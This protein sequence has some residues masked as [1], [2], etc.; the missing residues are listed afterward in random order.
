MAG[1]LSFIHKL[2]QSLPYTVLIQAV[3]RNFAN[4]QIKKKDKNCVVS[5]SIKCV[6][7][8]H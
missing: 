1:I 3:T 4:I 6:I 7:P 5:V 8:S 2:L